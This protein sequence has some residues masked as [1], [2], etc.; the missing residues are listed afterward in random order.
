MVASRENLN[1]EN[2][3][4]TIIRI[5]KPAENATV[6]ASSRPAVAPPQSRV[7]PNRSAREGKACPLGQSSPYVPATV[8]PPRAPRAAWVALARSADSTPDSMPNNLPGIEGQGA[9]TV[10]SLFGV[11]AVFAKEAFSD[12]M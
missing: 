1:L 8:P 9:T 11:F 3:N 12:E 5:L 2:L 10:A 4:T 6:Q 7:S